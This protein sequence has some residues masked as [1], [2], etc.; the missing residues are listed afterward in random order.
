MQLSIELWG[1]A[2]GEGMEWAH[3]VLEDGKIGGFLHSVWVAQTEDEHRG[4]GE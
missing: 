3:T 1:W 2:R 4:L